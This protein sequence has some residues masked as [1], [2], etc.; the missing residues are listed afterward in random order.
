[1]LVTLFPFCRFPAGKREKARFPFSWSHF[2]SFLVF[3]FRF[4]TSLFSFSQPECELENGKTSYSFAVLA[5]RIDFYFQAGKLTGIQFRLV[6][7]CRFPVHK[8]ARIRLL[9]FLPLSSVLHWF[10]QF[11]FNWFSSSVNSYLPFKMRWG[12]LEKEKLINL[13]RPNQILWK[14]SSSEFLQAGKKSFGRKS[15]SKRTFLMQDVLWCATWMKKTTTQTSVSCA[16][17]TRSHFFRFPVQKTETGKRETGKCDE[18]PFPPPP[19]SFP[20]FSFLCYV[21]S[22]SSLKTAKRQNGKTGKV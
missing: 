21:T 3:Q 16:T 2:S 1:M 15:K 13:V 17:E 11:I 22:F 12:K 10:C 7:C 20:V 19:S 14:K 18:T 5:N 8:R 4:L 6:Y 9:W